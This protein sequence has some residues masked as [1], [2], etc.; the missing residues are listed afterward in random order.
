MYLLSCLIQ[1]TFEPK[2]PEEARGDQFETATPVHIGEVEEESEEVQEK[3]SVTP[4]D[5]SP[6]EIHTEETLTEETNDAV[7]HPTDT[8][9]DVVT[10]SEIDPNSV[11]DVFTDLDGVKTQEPGDQTATR[12]TTV[13]PYTLPVSSSAPTTP[14]GPALPSVTLPVTDGI[15]TYEDMEG[16]ASRS[17]DDEAGALQ[18]GSA[19]DALPTP[20]AGSQSSV[21]TDETE[22]GGTELPTFIP[23]TQSRETTTQSQTDDY[24]GS[25]SGEDEAS[26]QDVYPPETPRLTSTLSPISSTLHTQQPQP[27]AHTEVTKV[28]VVLPDVDTVTETGSGVEQ[29]SGQG[30]VSGV[31]GDLVDLPREVTITFLPGVAAVTL[32]D[33]TT[34]T[35]DTEDITSEPST[36]K[37]PTHP[38]FAATDDE[39][40]STVATERAPTTPEDHTPPATVLD[41]LQTKQS[42]TTSKPYESQPTLSTTS[43]LYTFTHSTFSITEWALIPDPAATPLPE[44]DVVYDKEIVPLH[45]Q[46]PE[47]TL[48]TEQPET[49]TD[50]AYSVVA[51]TVNIRG[52]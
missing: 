30:E 14:S 12:T 40:H 16:S 21:M 51:S 25:A 26:G 6:I 29:L 46:I 18:E 13:T 31:Q 10:S 9:P 52:T 50:S 1:V 39:K 35:T 17:T 27:A 32:G 43:P 36:P 33:E 15:S 38:L 8:Y 22:I 44:D 28:P 2:L 47:E 49:D 42:T 5:Y 19:D 23:D 45:P 7:T 11:P 48:A 34:L 3:Q 4:F 20:A 41:T 24:E 37:F